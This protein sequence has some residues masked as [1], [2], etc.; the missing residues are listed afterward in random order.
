PAMI[1]AAIQRD[2]ERRRAVDQGVGMVAVP[3]GRWQIATRTITRTA[4]VNRCGLRRAITV[5][6][7]L[8]ARTATFGRLPAVTVVR[9]G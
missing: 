4:I 9:A 6:G 2:E 7:Y 3:T 5:V 1:E 8:N